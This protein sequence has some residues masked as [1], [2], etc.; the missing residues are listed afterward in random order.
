MEEIEIIIEVLECPD[1]F[2]VKMTDAGFAGA[3][4]AMEKED[5][6][7]FMELKGTGYLASYKQA[8][9]VF[10]YLLD[11]KQV[12]PPVCRFYGLLIF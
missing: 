5:S 6:I 1:I 12:S 7:F 9:Q 8:W 11:Q 4:T 10:M 2:P 3:D